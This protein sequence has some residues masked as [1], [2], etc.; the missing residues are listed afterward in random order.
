MGTLAD[1]TQQSGGTLTG[2]VDRL[3]DDGWSALCAVSTI[4]G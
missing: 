3:I 2:I 4:G 1:A